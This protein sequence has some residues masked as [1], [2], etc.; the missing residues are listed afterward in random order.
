MKRQTYPVILN[1]TS[2]RVTLTVVSVT[3]VSLFVFREMQNVVLQRMSK[4]KQ[5][6]TARILFVEQNK[7]QLEISQLLGVTTKTVN[8]WV[9]E[10]KWK[11]EQDARSA[12]PQRRIENIKAIIS[13]MADERLELDRKVKIA[14]ANADSEEST[15]LRERISQ[16]DDAISKWNK[17]LTNLQ[18]E[19]RVT[20]D[21][22]LRVM[23]RIFDD[24]RIFSPKLYSDTVDFQEQHLH[25]VTEELG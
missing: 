25:K 17:T 24:M 7:T 13:N 3:V 14:E 10:G 2:F 8:T 12:S 6:K 16:V 9:R 11:E 20:L 23:D 15:E 22:Y 4:E 18:D 1:D 19:N 21:V 5:K